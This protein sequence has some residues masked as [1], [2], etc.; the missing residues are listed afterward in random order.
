MDKWATSKRLEDIGGDNRGYTEITEETIKRSLEFGPPMR[1]KISPTSPHYR[2]GSRSNPI[3]VTGTVIR[4]ANP[5]VDHNVHVRWD[6]ESKNS[7]RYKDLE[8]VN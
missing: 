1:V 3:D 7:Y 6:N 4:I 5:F 8:I 2:P